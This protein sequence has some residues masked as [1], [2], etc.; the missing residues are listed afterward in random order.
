MKLIQG[1]SGIRGIVEQT[2]TE[3]I[4][5]KYT[6]AFSMIQGDGDILIARD[7]RKHGKDFIKLGCQT[8]QKCGRNIQN[9]GIIPTPTAQFL[10]EKHKLAGGIMIT[11]S[12][13]PIEWNGLKFIRG[14]GT[15]FRPDECDNLFS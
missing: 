11:A 9:F 4:L 13:N 14:D 5:S 12:H 6:Q 3:S 2:F 15:F 7:S 8:L 10:V 1:I